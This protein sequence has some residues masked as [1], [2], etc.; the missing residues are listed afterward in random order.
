[1]ASSV[2]IRRPGI[3]PAKPKRRR[4]KPLLLKAGQLA[5]RLQISERSVQTLTARGVLPSIKLG[6]K[7]VRYRLADVDRALAAMSMPAEA[8]GQG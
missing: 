4:C 5:R 2:V 7:L 1:M 3:S 8:R 6:D